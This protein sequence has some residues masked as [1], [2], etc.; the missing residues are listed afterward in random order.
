MIQAEHKEWVDRMFPGQ[1]PEMPA[2]VMLEEAGELVQALA[3][4]SQERRYGKEPRYTAVDWRAKL[5]D[6]VGDCAISACSLCNANGW[7]FETL[8]G[9]L[10][11]SATDDP[12]YIAVDV[13]Q[14]AVC[15]VIDP[16]S[17]ACCADYLAVLRRLCVS[18]D[19]SF[20]E[21]VRT[22]WDQVKRRSREQKPAPKRV[23]LCGSTRFYSQFQK[24]NYEETMVG[25]IVLSVGFYQHALE[26]HEGQGCTPEQKVA[27]DE[28][29]LRKIDIA[30]EVLV[31]NVDG[32]IGESTRNEIAY[33]EKIGK[34][35]RY[36][37][38]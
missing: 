25:N 21:C 35:V 30:D 38:P 2:A 36:L 20:E 4:T 34:P 31:L 15:Q 7:D 12:L 37:E 23:C 8:C 3:K 18:I 5:V 17:V 27:L 28:L 9:N 6:A 33:A 14:A 1:L 11:K 29:H 26:H 19:L 32:Y 22:T 13:V 24:S 16:K 10:A